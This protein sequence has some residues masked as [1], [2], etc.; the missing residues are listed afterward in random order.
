MSKAKPFLIGTALGASAMF[1]ALQY[2]VVHTHNG[3]QI[4]PRAPQQSVGLAYAD[5]RNWTP[6]Q[7]TDR[8]ELARALMAHGSSDLISASVSKTLAD[9]VSEDS[10]TLEEL[11]AF[12]NKS[13]TQAPET[14]G[15]KPPESGSNENSGAVIP[16]NDIFRIPFP[17]DAKN[18]PKGAPAQQTPADPFRSLRTADADAGDERAPG[19]RFSTAD[20]LAGLKDEPA[21]AGK[22]VVPLEP[23]PAAASG[24]RS[25]AEQAKAMED[26]IFGQGSAAP[27][28]PRT[29]N[30]SAA[31]GQA[32]KA[33]QP[34]AAE[35]P[36]SMFEEVSTQ[37]ENRAQEALN[38][39]RQTGSKSPESAAGKTSE[40]IS[41]DFIRNKV[42]QVLSGVTGSSSSAPAAAVP[43]PS[44]S[45]LKDF[46]PFL[47]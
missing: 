45:S 42:Q 13:A 14:F 17:Q 24:N 27:G 47:E 5:I 20:V 32:S 33:A 21:L 35:A 9:S 7:W 16:E 43:A 4:L 37:L 26:R 15:Q 44:T 10:S 23:R 30:S 36:E 34:T 6:S 12:L 39:A 41:P 22:P 19:A 1:V 25:V 29:A 46:D 3:F 11:R 40:A 28:Q 18:V 38:R 31:N 8:P 2:H